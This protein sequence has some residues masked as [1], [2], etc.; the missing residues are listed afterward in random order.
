MHIVY[1][2]F[3]V[4]YFMPRKAFDRTAQEKELEVIITNDYLF[5]DESLLP[6]TKLLKQCIEVEK[7][8]QI[9]GY[10]KRL[11]SHRSKRIILNL[12]NSLVWPHLEYTVPFCCPLYRKDITRLARVQFTAT[13]LILCV[14]NERYDYC[15]RNQNLFQMETQ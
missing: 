3:Q 2:N 15:L 7:K 4:E 13:K 9:F 5:D 14:R 12:Y 1:Y 10:M 8:L 11:F 6:I